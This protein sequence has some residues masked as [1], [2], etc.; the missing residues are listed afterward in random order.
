MSDTSPELLGSLDFLEDILEE[1]RLDVSLLEADGSI[2]IT[3]QGMPDTDSQLGSSSLKDL[4]RSATGSFEQYLANST[5]QSNALNGQPGACYI[6]ATETIAGQPSNTYNGMVV[7]DAITI[8]DIPHEPMAGGHAAEQH[9]V[10]PGYLN[11][12]NMSD[13]AADINTAWPM[14]GCDA[15]PASKADASASADAH[16]ERGSIGT[17]AATHHVQE[18]PMVRDPQQQASSWC[19]DAPGSSSDTGYHTRPSTS[20]SMYSNLPSV[21]SSEPVGIPQNAGSHQM[22]VAENAMNQ[23]ISSLMVCLGQM[24]ASSPQNWPHIIASHGHSLAANETGDQAGRSCPEVLA[25]VLKGLLIFRDALVSILLKNAIAMPWE[26][27]PKQY[28]KE[29][30]L[31]RLQFKQA[32]RNMLQECMPLTAM[33]C[34]RFATVLREQALDI[35][36]KI[37]VWHPY[38]TH[39]KDRQRALASYT[40]LT[41]QQ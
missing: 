23:E 4:V 30:G 19:S 38:I 17:P 40:H 36:F 11:P 28:D 5:P 6:L 12:G 18:E 9:A 24:G 26:E 22:M 7:S 10:N 37:Y 3:L 33:L 2:R 34:N 20:T 8:H 1:E 35:Y 15:Y 31:R 14:A 16:A 21:N 39:N 41:Q 13:E 32:M 29:T 27:D 25:E